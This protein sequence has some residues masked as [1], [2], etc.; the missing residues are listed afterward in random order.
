[1]LQYI[2][3]QVEIG[4]IRGKNTPEIGGRYFS[5]GVNTSHKNLS[6]CHFCPSPL[7]KMIRKGNGFRG[8]M[9]LVSRYDKGRHSYRK[10]E[11]VR[12]GGGS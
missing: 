5:R 10:I 6:L 1:M 12:R 4:V 3:N 7:R 8:E 11:G 2:V 9:P